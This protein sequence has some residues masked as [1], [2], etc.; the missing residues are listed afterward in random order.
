VVRNASL[1]T[2][3]AGDAGERK[4]LREKAAHSKIVE[5]GDQPAMGEVA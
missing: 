4:R 3:V 1:G 2:F 5:C